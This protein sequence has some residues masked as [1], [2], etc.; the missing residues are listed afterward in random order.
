MQ[1]DKE[2]FISIIENQM[3]NDWERQF[4]KVSFNGNEIQIDVEEAVF[5]FDK[6]TERFVGMFNYKE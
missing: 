5:V 3:E 6:E 4:Y 1:T 2:K